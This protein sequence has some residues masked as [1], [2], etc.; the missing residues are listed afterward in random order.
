MSAAVDLVVRYHEAMARR[1]IEA[2]MA[3]MHPQ[4]RFDDFVDGGEVAGSTAVRAFY[5]RLFET[6]A[7]DMDL[8]AVHALPDGRVRGDIQVVAHD[9]SGNIWSDTRS[10]AVYAIVD[11]L[12][13]GIELQPD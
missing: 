6:L 8:L 10:F 4:A 7:P 9:R 5:Q 13:H 2:V 3:T 12:I 11:G 1:D